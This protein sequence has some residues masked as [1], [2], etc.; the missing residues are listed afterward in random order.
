MIYTGEEVS[1]TDE[2]FEV[3]FGLE[4]IVAEFFWNIV[5]AVALLA[6]SKSRALK[7]IHKYIDEKHEVSHDKY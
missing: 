4:H 3:M 2:L 5:F 7:K 6:I 1:H